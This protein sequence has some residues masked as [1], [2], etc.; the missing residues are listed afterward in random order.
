MADF[1][2]QKMF[3]SAA[4]TTPYRLLTKDHISLDSFDGK[5]MLKIAP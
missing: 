2:Y 3:P 4:D 5:Q 1:V